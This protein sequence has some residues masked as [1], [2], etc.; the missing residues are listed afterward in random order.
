MKTEDNA[1][2]GEFPLVFITPE[3][4]GDAPY[5]RLGRGCLLYLH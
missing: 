4:V 5:V 3:K 1:I 2:A